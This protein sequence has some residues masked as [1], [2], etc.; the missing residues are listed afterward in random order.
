MGRKVRHLEIRLSLGKVLEVPLRQS[1]K[2]LKRWYELKLRQREEGRTN[3]F[4]THHVWICIREQITSTIDAGQLSDEDFLPR[5]P[6]L[7]LKARII[8]LNQST[9]VNDMTYFYT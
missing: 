1:A 4:V 2:M 5:L 7:V 3:L 8:G 6:P 9:G